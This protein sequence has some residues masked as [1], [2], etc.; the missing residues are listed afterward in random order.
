MLAALAEQAAYF[1]IQV[2][3]YAA[4]LGRFTQ[5]GSAYGSIYFTLL[6]AAHAHVAVGV[7]LDLWLLAKLLRGFTRYRHNALEAI[8]FYWWAVYA[9]TVVITLTVLSPSL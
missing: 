1:G 9:L 2:H 5:Q 4:D 8:S 3:E 6:G 7:L